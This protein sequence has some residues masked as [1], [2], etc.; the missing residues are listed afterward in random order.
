MI[1]GKIEIESIVVV[2]PNDEPVAIIDEEN[3]VEK[4][5]YKVIIEPAD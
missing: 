1:R 2:N 3:V 5:G 4:D